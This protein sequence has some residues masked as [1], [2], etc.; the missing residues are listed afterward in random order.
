MMNSLVDVYNW[1]LAHPQLALTI[2]TALAGTGEAARRYRRTGQV[3]LSTLPW[4]AFRRLYYRLRKHFFTVRRPKKPTFTLD[5]SGLEA[6]RTRLGEDSYEPGWPL[7]YYYYGEDLNARRYYFQPDAEY[8]HR[9]I[10]IRGFELDDDSVELLA[11]DEPAPKHHP[12]AHLNE[13]DIHDATEWLEGQWRTQSI[14]PRTYTID[15]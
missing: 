10:H 13:V 9:Q 7:S 12:R 3:P 5:G 14:D 15:E 4:R 11:H 8:P 6:V 1:L 2:F